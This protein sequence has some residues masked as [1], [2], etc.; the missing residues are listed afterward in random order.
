MRFEYRSY[1]NVVYFGTGKLEILPDL[2]REN[3]KVMVIAS[4]RLTGHVDALKAALGKDRVIQFSKVIQHVPDTLVKE[5]ADV[6]KHHR[7]DTL[8]AIGGGSAVGLAKALSLEEYI[9]QIAIPSTFS[10]S[11][12]TN[13][14]GISSAGTKKTG[15]H[16][17]VLPG[18]VIY[19]PILTLTMPKNLAV[20]SAMNA[21]A[22]LMEAI[23]SPSGNP[24]TTNNAMLGMKA[25]QAGL[26]TLADTDKLT[27][28][29]NE[30]ILFGA[31][32][33]GKCLCE[34]AMG[35]HHRVAHVLGGTFGMEHASVHTVLQS[36]TLAYQWLHLAE[37]IQNDFKLALESD[38]P[39]R[40][41]K[42]LAGNAGAKTNLKS[43]GFKDKDIESAAEIISSMPYANVAPVSKESIVEMLTNAYEGNLA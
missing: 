42:A 5:A 28:S 7:P 1:P 20:T 32:L 40:T 18:I 29:A 11:E 36:Y 10:G 26:K 19:D 31:Y 22:H 43:I 2:L 33:G 34:V 4:E 6:R 41:L 37:P 17:N 25:I 35:L 14:Y 38:N 8:V 16:D 15:R 9:P 3:H 21:M 12:Q 13:I 24:I 30:K 23:Y 39:A 27:K